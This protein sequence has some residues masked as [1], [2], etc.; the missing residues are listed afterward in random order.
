MSNEM[1]TY[2][3]FGAGGLFIVIISIWFIVNNKLKSKEKK[4][5]A[6][7]TEGTKTSNFSMDI[8]YQK[9]YIFCVKIPFLKRYVLKIRRR[10]EIINLDDEYLTR[11]QTAK[12]LVRALL[13]IIPLT[14]VVVYLTRGN[15]ILTLT[16]FLFEIFFIE[17]FMEGM[18]D[19]LDNKLLREQ[20]DMFG[21]MRHSYHEYNMI[22]E[23]LYDVAQNDEVEVSR[24]VEKIHEVLISDDPE[25]ELEKYYDIAP[26]SYL[27]EFAGVSYLTKEFGDRKDKDGAS[28]YLKNLNNIVQEMQMEILKRDK[29]DYVFQSLSM[30]AAVPI[31]FLDV[32]KNWAMGQFAFTSEFYNGTK[33]FLAQMA[34]V[35]LTIVCYIFVR[36]LK[37]NGSVNATTNVENPWQKKLYKKAIIKK[38][39]DY[40]MPKDGT[41]EYKK[42]TKLLKDNA[43]KL[44]MEW[45]YINRVSCTIISFILAMFIIVEGHQY[46]VNYIYTEPTTDY[47]LLGNLSEKEHKTAMQK[48]ANDNVFL[49]KYKND[50]SITKEAL[51][52][53]I[54]KSEEYGDSKSAEIDIITDRIWNKLQVIQAEYLKWFELLIACLVAA[55]GYYGPIWLLMFQKKM[56]QMEMENEVMQFQTIIL[57][58]MKIERVNVEMILE[59]LERYAN[60][61]KEPIS[62]CVN[63]F[64]SGAWEALEDLKNE[65]S[66]EQLITLVEGL[67]SA[68]ESIPIREAFDELDTERAYYQEKRKESNDRLI[69]RKSMIGKVLGF[70]PMV[71]MFV[72]YLIIPLCVIGLTSMTSA[73]STM[74]SM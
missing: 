7:L 69:A 37:D 18:V 58:L 48:T 43:S 72:G 35:I 36:S 46:A 45:L 22:E 68:V 9:I 41:K 64:E 3:M 49:D 5:I 24:Q 70:A 59:W 73:F 14:S 16:L 57:M 34:I 47:N 23:A 65:L 62:R 44:K 63:N 67:Q 8:F 25:N 52:K 74:S 17:T 71:I 15:I 2:L 1:L 61:F 31:L 20:I 56:R 40:I 19:K 42:V 29:L 33:G 11:S 38:F 21:E 53:D 12:I 51:K 55:L 60:I 50:L 39:V 26:N 30:I 10:I 6:Q 27:K 4:Y 13:I 32:M 28:L 54:S 66:F